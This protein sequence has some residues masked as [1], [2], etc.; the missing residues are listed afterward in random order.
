MGCWVWPFHLKVII[1]YLSP[2]SH[3]QG[4]LAL[5]TVSQNK[6]GVAT[7]LVNPIDSGMTSFALKPSRG[8]SSMHVR[9]SEVGV[10][11]HSA[12]TLIFVCC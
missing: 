6:R 5:T 7:M 1:K 9:F 10:A 11:F 3:T 4:D 12:L 8:V 2:V